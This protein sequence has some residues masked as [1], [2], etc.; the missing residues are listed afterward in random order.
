M[1]ADFR[2]LEILTGHG[3]PFVVIGG[4]AVVFHGW[5]RATEDL[6]IIWLRSPLAE[7]KL[8]AALQEMEAQYVSDELDPATGMERTYPVTASFVRARSLM[9]LC[10]KFGFLDLF[11]YVP[12]FPQVPVTELIESSVPGGGWQFVSLDWLR[13]LKQ[14]SGRPKDRLD[15]ENLPAVEHPDL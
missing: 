10:T 9:M 12:G 7:T 2:L 3:V 14:A 1:I 8:L 15:L 6:D 13:R 5:V 11:D 4:H